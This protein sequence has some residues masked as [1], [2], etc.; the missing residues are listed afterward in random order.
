MI[1]IHQILFFMMFSFSL[2]IFSNVYIHGLLYEVVRLVDNICLA[3]SSDFPNLH[4]CFF[5][6]QIF[7]NALKKLKFFKPGTETNPASKSC[8]YY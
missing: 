5:F 4:Y 1:S 3:I 2:K 8:K 6:L 7:N